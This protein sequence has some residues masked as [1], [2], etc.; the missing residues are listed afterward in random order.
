MIVNIVGLVFIGALASCAAEI[1]DYLINKW[2]NRNPPFDGSGVLTL[3]I[4][5]AE[6]LMQQE[7]ENQ[8][9]TV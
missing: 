7:S 2:E 8:E 6:W 3:D 5:V 4:E 9:I 1:A